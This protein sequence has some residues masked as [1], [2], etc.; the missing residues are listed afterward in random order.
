[1][2][3][4]SGD[5]HP[6]RS[7]APTGRGPRQ[8]GGKERD[9]SV[10]TAT[11]DEPCDRATPGGR[12]PMRVC[13][14]GATGFLGAHI[15]RLLCER[16]EQVQVTCRDPERPGPLGELEASRAKADVSDYRALRRAFEG[17]DVV[18]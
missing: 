9:V 12:C 10:A 18:V 13:V 11:F 3:G 2:C 6:D 14:T 17:A 7:A 8:P 16:G 4:R 5:T 15:V 1:M